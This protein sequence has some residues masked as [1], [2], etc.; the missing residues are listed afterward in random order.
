MRLLR[1]VFVAGMALALAGCGTGRIGMAGADTKPDIKELGPDGL[2][3]IFWRIKQENEAAVLALINAGADIEAQGYHGS[4]PLLTTAQLANWPL[5]LAL[6]ERGANVGA[7]DRIG[8][9]L[10]YLTTQNN[11]AP[12]TPNGV[13]LQAV[14][15]YLNDRLMLERVYKPAEVRDLMAKGQWPPG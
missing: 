1:R 8:F 4:T 6:I 13:A 5:V 9:N 10:P 12:D 7:V 14:R 3:I 2:P 15:V 11:P